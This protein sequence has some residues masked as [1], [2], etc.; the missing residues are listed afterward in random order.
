MLVCVDA[1]VCAA[2]VCA[3]LVS[4][5]LECVLLNWCVVSSAA[6]VCGA[7]MCC[8]VVWWELLDSHEKLHALK[9]T[10]LSRSGARYIMDFN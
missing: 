9:H 7:D 1:L 4:A 3:A 8:T 5:A 10:S 2:L 6:L